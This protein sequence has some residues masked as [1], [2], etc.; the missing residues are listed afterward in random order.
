MWGS[1]LTRLLCGSKLTSFLCAGRKLHG[2]NVRMAIDLFFCVQDENYLFWVGKSIILVLCWSTWFCMRAGNHLVWVWVA[3]LTW[4]LC[5]WSKFTW[6][7]C[8]GWN[9][10]W[11]Q[12]K[13]EID[14]VPVWVVELTWFHCGELTRFQCRDIIG[15]GVVWVVEIDSIS[16]WGIGID[17]DFSVE[18]IMELTLISV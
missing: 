3:K 6:L 13:A 8:R 10:T 1:K 12:C 7:Q 15:L 4:F 18:I 11:F 17:F 16:V 2:F 14:L 5:G 9:L